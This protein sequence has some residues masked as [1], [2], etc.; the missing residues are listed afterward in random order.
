MIFAHKNSKKN[1]VNRLLWELS[2][3]QYWPRSG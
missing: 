1:Y 2:N 3:D